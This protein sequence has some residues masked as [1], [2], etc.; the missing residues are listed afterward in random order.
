MSAD[1]VLLEDF[2]DEFAAELKAQLARDEKRYG[3][4]WRH[5][6]LKGQEGRAFATFDNYRDRFRYGGNPI[7]W[8]KVAGEALIAWV[9]ENHPET[10]LT[11]EPEA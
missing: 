11:E 9:R 2:V 4:T 3:D 7:P 10:L 1:P 5:R 6:T 8:L